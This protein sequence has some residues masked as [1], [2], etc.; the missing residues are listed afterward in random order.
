MATTLRKSFTIQLRVIRALLMREILTRYG[1]DNIGFL[2]LFVEPMIFILGMT[3]LFASRGG[4][5]ISGV[6]IIPFLVTG[7]SSVLMWRNAAS[8]CSKA[9]LPNLSLLYHRNVTILDLFLARI[10]LEIAG[11]SMALIAISVLLIGSDF[12]ALPVDILSMVVGWFLLAFFATGLGLIIGSLTELFDGF[13]RI[14]QI[15]TFVS[16]PLSGAFFMVDWLP[17]SAQEMAL[18][19]PMIHGVEMM[20]EGYYGPMVKAHYS[21]SYLV[22]VNFTMLFVGLILVYKTKGHVGSE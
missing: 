4:M 18:W 9:I 16:F 19:I 6:P 21:I 7:Y 2:W 17:K 12:M 14:W 20:R 10:L 5:F 13:D 15:M 3:A 8:R 11:A 22:I 1:R